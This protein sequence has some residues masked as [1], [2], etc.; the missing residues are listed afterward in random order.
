MARQKSKEIKTTRVRY[1]EDGPMEELRGVY[2]DVPSSVTDKAAWLESQYREEMAKA[3]AKKEREARDE[4]VLADRIEQQRRLGEQLPDRVAALEAELAGLKQLQSEIPSTT[5]L[6]NIQTG[7]IASHTSLLNGEQFLAAS[8]RELEKNA[9]TQHEQALAVGETFERAKEL[10][11]Q[12]LEVNRNRLE[13][14][15]Q[16]QEASAKLIRERDERIAKEQEHSRELSNQIAE[17]HQI[18]H[19]ARQLDQASVEKQKQLFNQAVEQV[20]AELTDEFV[21]MM[22]LLIT[23]LGLTED[24]LNLTANSVDMGSKSAVRL[25]HRQIQFFADVMRKSAP[26]D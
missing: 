23:S 7:I 19:A 20:K 14:S 8:S 26:K 1:P 5:D 24:T 25:S 21:E 4:R 11:A 18:V 15:N 17:N 13:L 3:L 9:S 16:A 6:Q 22:N 2:A 12:T 10:Q